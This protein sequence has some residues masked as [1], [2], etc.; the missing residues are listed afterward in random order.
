VVNSVP[1][2]PARLW[3]LC[4]TSRRRHTWKSRDDLSVACRE[5]TSQYLDLILQLEMVVSRRVVLSLGRDP[6][7]VLKCSFYNRGHTRY[8]AYQI[9]TL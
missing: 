8:P 5:S 7:W 1:C 9:F 6:F 2:L 4:G 3:N